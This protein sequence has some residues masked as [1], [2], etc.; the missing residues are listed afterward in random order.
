MKNESRYR[1]GMRL[2]KILGQ[3]DVKKRF[4]TDGAEPV[5]GS[6]RDFAAFLKADYEKWG[7][8]VKETGIRA[9]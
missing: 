7:R 3:D 5:G 4:A 2:R 6:P 1:S 9:D 8:V